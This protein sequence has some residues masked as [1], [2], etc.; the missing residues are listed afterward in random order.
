MAHRH[1]YEF[2]IAIDDMN[3]KSSGVSGVCQIKKKKHGT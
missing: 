1:W 3:V 2:A